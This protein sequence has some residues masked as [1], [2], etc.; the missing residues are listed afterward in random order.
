ME[1]RIPSGDLPKTLIQGKATEAI[2]NIAHLLEFLK[3]EGEDP[4]ERAGNWALGAINNH[5]FITGPVTEVLKQFHSASQI[6]G[7]KIK[8][9]FDYTSIINIPFFIPYLEYDGR[10]LVVKGGG[11]VSKTK[12]DITKKKIF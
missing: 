5:K 1:R 3:E 4:S 8:V 7:K 6:T 12:K 9:K 2:S 11:I 10:K